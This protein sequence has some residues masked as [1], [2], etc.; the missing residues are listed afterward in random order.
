MRA[1]TYLCFR[2][3]LVGD[4]LG[5]WPPQ[6]PPL[7][8]RTAPNFT[9][10]TRAYLVSTLASPTDSKFFLYARKALDALFPVKHSCAPYQ[11][12]SYYTWTTFEVE[13]PKIFCDLSTDWPGF[14]SGGSVDYVRL[15]SSYEGPPLARRFDFISRRI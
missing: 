8:W 5:L 13:L 15:Q 3:R 1:F 14:V 12:K 6:Q 4:D 2:R 9:E 7:P 10:R 11:T